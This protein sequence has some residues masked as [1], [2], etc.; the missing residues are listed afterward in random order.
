MLVLYNEITKYRYA[1]CTA[2]KQKRAR[3]G[4]T[5]NET[6]ETSETRRKKTLSAT[7]TK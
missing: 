7:S 5:I 6:T 2:L 3:D 4:T 1:H